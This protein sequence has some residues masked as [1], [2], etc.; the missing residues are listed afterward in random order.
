MLPKSYVVFKWVMYA[1]ATLFLC[2]LQSVVFNHIHVFRLTPF[3]Y[4]VLPALVAMFEGARPGAVFALCFGLACD[5][6]V[7]APFRGFFVLIFPV[8]AVVSAGIAGRLLSRGFLCGGVVSAAGLVLTACFR[9]FIQILSGGEYLGLMARIA[10]GEV[11]LTIPAVVIA[12]PLYRM[13][14]RRCG[15]EY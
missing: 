4:P 2:A 1:V 9:L 7:P 12:L 11:I 3:L 10:L 13:I 15:A 8:A 5:L 6:L 14:Y